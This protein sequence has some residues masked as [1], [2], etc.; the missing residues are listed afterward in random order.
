MLMYPAGAPSVKCA[1]CHFITNVNVSNNS[2]FVAILS[3]S[4]FHSMHLKRKDSEIVVPDKFL[5]S[6]H[7]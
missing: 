4:L 1:L 7:Y 2:Y 3:V 5:G 6:S